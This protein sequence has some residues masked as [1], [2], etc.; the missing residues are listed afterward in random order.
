MDIDTWRDILDSGEIFWSDDDI[1]FLSS[2]NVQIVTVASDSDSA[3]CKITAVN[4]NAFED[5]QHWAE[6]EIDMYPDFIFPLKY[7]NCAKGGI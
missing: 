3:D 1:E 2:S 7:K 5:N 6:D 4:L